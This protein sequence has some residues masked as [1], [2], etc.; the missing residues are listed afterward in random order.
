MDQF[1]DWQ[2]PPAITYD[3]N[4]FI[5]NL[6]PAYIS[7][8]EQ[9][10][11]NTTYPTPILPTSSQRCLQ[12]LPE[13]IRQAYKI[14]YD[15]IRRSIGQHQ[16]PDWDL[17]WLEAV[18]SPPELV[19]DA[20]KAHF[21]QLFRSPAN[22]TSSN[23]SPTFNAQGPA[24][25]SASSPNGHS[26]TNPTSSHTA[27][28]QPAIT[29]LGPSKAANDQPNQPVSAVSMSP[30]ALKAIRSNESWKGWIYCGVVRWEGGDNRFEAPDG[31]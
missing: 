10:P 6:D 11:A 15:A 18:L 31:R 19:K 13:D 22:S 9:I 17:I 3:P 12:L 21:D 24:P 25:T 1:N 30:A 7:A 2:H 28:T 4:G 16:R 27:I 29:P 26:E 20:L 8:A 5:A 23:T 14:A